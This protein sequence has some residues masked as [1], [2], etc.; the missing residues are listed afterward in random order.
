MELRK[1]PEQS[2]FELVRDS[3]VIGLIDYVELGDV[4]DLPHTW[5][6]PVYR[7]RGLS[8]RLIEFALEDARAAGVS[9]RPTCPAIAQYIAKH[10]A[11]ADLVEK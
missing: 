10:D 8:Q 1:H 2:R 6:D 4:W 9:V 7:G 3:E 11:Y 5:V